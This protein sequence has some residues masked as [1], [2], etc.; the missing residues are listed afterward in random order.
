MITFLKTNVLQI[1][2]I[3][4]KFPINLKQLK[5]GKLIQEYQILG[6]D[7]DKEFKR[8]YKMLTKTI[9]AFLY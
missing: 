1:A 7:Q 4:I 3:Q 2:L 6:L 8:T 9:Q 5:K